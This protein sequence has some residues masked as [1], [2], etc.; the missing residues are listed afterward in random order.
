MYSHHNTQNTGTVFSTCL[1]TAS[2][3]PPSSFLIL[4][5]RCYSFQFQ[6]I[7]STSFCIWKRIHGIFCSLLFPLNIM[8]HPND[9][10]LFFILLSNILWHMYTRISLSIHPFKGSVVNSIYIG[11]DWQCYS[12]HGS[13]GIFLIYGFNFFA[14]NTQYW[15]IWE[16]FLPS[17]L[18]IFS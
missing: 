17:S 10:I 9:R 6:E 3:Y 12:K 5:S 16:F 8:F 18:N 4:A 13:S 15:I 7:N 11:H 2:L 1:Q 14:M